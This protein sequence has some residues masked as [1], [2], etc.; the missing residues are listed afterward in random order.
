MRQLIGSVLLTILLFSCGQR[1]IQLPQT[2][3]NTITE[4]QDVSPVYIFYNEDDASVEFNRKNLIS[5]T[6]WLVNIDKRVTF[7]QA[8]PHLKY[9]LEKRQK[10]NMHKNENARN[11]FTCFNPETK[12]LS[13]IDF[14][15]TSYVSEFEKQANDFSE[16]TFSYMIKVVSQDKIEVEEISEGQG[17][18]E[19][20]STITELTNEI[21]GLL[22]QGTTRI[23]LAFNAEVSFQD[24][25]D[26]KSKILNMKSDNLLISTTEIIY[27]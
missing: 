11:Y 2:D 4:I 3:L 19:H 16:V 17:V 13:F 20:Y 15:E 5:T 7:K 25:V 10:A 23:T 8:L 1:E 27:N 22:K 14:T 24:Y 6:N 26:L 18:I 12:G 9:L 21:E